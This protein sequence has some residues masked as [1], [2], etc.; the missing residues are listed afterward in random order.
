M[1]M[2]TCTPPPA[3]LPP[4][5]QRGM[6]CKSTFSYAFASSHTFQEKVN[7]L[8][9]HTNCNLQ[10][11]RDQ[12][13]K[14]VV[15]SKWIVHCKNETCGSFRQKQEEKKKTFQHKWVLFCRKMILQCSHLQGS[16]MTLTNPQPACNVNV[17]LGSR[18]LK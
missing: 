17:S 9:F 5:A 16:A 4:P 2:W 11:F 10:P 6:G 18:A 7:L 14:K 3:V 8:G 1:N 13:L 15:P 12:S